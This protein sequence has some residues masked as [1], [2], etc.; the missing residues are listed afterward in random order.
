MRT[1]HVFAARS[2]TLALAVALP[3]VAA[4]T[5]AAADADPSV[6]AKATELFRAGRA[7]AA[8]GDDKTACERFTESEQL[9]PAP[10]TQL[11]LGACEEKQGHLLAARE[12]F[13]K[14]ASAFGPEDRRRAVA[15]NTAGALT[16]RLAILTVH[17][18]TTS[19]AGTKVAV[20][21]AVLD[22]G[23]LEHGIEVDPGKTTLLITAEG[24][25]PR[26][27]DLTLAEGEK[28][29][30]S[31][32]AGEA[33]APAPEAPA[34]VVHNDSADATRSLERTLGF[35]GMG[36]G[37]AGIAVG[38]IFGALALHE[39]SVVKANCN[40]TT[41]ACQAPGVSAASS[42]KTDGVVST[43]GFIAGGVFA[44]AGVYL[45]VRTSGGDARG[46]TTGLFLAPDVSPRGAE[47]VTGT[48]V[49]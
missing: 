3:L 27:L 43:V 20:A 10:G 4:R 19:P 13:R 34:P 18:P 23:I 35:A 38:S 17:I 25:Q 41:W 32:E 49:F 21:G 5:A 12:H 30:V 16:D 33:V 26:T 6:T 15:V 48:W 36:A 7:A 40:T 46:K 11:N 42:G 29:E 8:A 9:Q 14:A 37:V 1:F 22:P 47:G 28:H 24:R 2:L 31:A 44:A 45:F 39:A